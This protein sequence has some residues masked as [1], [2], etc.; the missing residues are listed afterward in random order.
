LSEQNGFAEWLHYGRFFYGWSL[1]EL[2]QLEH[3]IAEM[4]AA[5]AGFR[6]M[7]GM[8]NQQYAM[9]LLAF[10]YGKIGQIPKALEKL[11]ECLATIELM[12]EKLAYSEVLRLKGELLLMHDA[13]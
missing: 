6:Q 11:D 9:A 10:S 4:E 13:D 3:G 8:A 1:T 12:G 7:G 5:V 2:G